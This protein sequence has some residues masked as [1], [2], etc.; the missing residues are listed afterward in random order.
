MRR[1]HR[2]KQIKKNKC[3]KTKEQMKTGEEKSKI[4]GVKEEN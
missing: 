4:K 3:G 1:Q 2:G